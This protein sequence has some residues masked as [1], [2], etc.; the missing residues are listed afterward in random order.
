M[1][2]SL[3][4]VEIPTESS[5][6]YRKFKSPPKVEI[7]TGSSNP[8]RNFK[9]LVEMQIPTERSNPYRKFKS[10]P[11]GQI[12]TERSNP[13]RRC[14]TMCSPCARIG[15]QSLLFSFGIFG[16]ELV[17][18]CSALDLYLVRCVCELLGQSSWIVESIQAWLVLVCNLLIFVAAAT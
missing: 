5:N 13:Y 11:K 10:L 8:Y 18:D 7:P 4:K 16:T 14:F 9:F 1:I 12:H 3:L 17:L 6:P 2:K 15:S